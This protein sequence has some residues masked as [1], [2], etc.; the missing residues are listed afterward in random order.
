MINSRTTQ[1]ATKRSGDLSVSLMLTSDA[2]IFPWRAGGHAHVYYDREAGFAVPAG[3]GA[4]SGAHGLLLAR[5]V[6]IDVHSGRIIGER[7]E[8]Q[9]AVS[10]TGASNVV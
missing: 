7:R 2:A 4:I 1:M 10:V 5:I 9:V 8:Q 6:M 3:A